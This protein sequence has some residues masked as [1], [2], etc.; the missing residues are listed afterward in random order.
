[1]GL[2]ELN[3]IPFQKK[4]SDSEI[5]YRR[6]NLLCERY[7]PIKSVD[8]FWR[9]SRQRKLQ[10]PLQGWK[11]HISATIVEA[12]DLF[13]KIAPLMIE[14]DVQF[15][16]PNSLMNLFRINCGLHYGYHQIGKFVTVYPPD[17]ESA[18]ILAKRLHKLTKE[19]TP[20]IIPF[21]NQYLPKSSIFYRYGA[22]SI[23]EVLN[24]NGKKFLALENQV[25]ELIP[26]D[27]RRAVPDWVSNPFPNHNKS[28]WKSFA[29]T[30]LGTT[31][32]I[33]QA[34]TQRGKGGTYRAIDFSEAQPRLCIIK[35]GRRNGELSWNGQDGCILVKNEF[36]VLKSIHRKYDAVPKVLESFKVNG[37]FYFAMEFVEGKNL[38]DQIKTRRRR[39]SIKKVIEF[40]VEI[41]KII[42]RIHQTGWVWNDCKPTNLIV[43]GEKRLRPIDFEG[44]YRIG[45]NEPF[46]W[47]SKGFS[48]FVSGTASDTY[49]FGAVVYFLLT[50]KFFN[51]DNSIPVK[52]LRR[53]VPQN[54]INEIEK[55]LSAK[56][57]NVTPTRVFFER[58]L[59][60]I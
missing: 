35:E 19:F 32:R 33:F 46:E 2:P 55:L 7:L 15:K 14:E 8:S 11:L 48:T 31:Y 5:H 28:N 42:E 18:V 25:G 44:S 37:N 13:E 38:F 10:E 23:I 50:G 9:A 47:K 29:E 34:I 21:D 26:D 60:S 58:M 3:K 53:N 49:A 20:I 17:E 6:W 41:A 52:Q 27:R 39:L 4:I 1:M 59:K 56:I 12:C 36:A 57:V 54:L 43:A 22:F 16:A 24:R 40:G 30:P 45:E 51:K